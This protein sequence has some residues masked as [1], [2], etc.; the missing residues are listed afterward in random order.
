VGSF[1]CLVAVVWC[2]VWAVSCWLGDRGEGSNPTT[3]GSP[4]VPR[5]GGKYRSGAAAGVGGRLESTGLP[6]AHRA[7]Q[8]TVTVDV[9]F[10]PTIATQ[11]SRRS[12]RADSIVHTFGAGNVSTPLG[13]R[14]NTGQ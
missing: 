9:T 6:T 4:S 14:P 10:R 3:R 13:S 7:Q 11:R 12:P 8:I 2:R 5:P 1:Y